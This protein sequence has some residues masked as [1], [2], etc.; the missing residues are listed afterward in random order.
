MRVRI[1]V[2]N[3]SEARFYDSIGRTL[4][5]SGA[6]INPAGRVHERDLVSD[7]PGRVFDRAAVSGHRRGATARHATGPEHT[8]R[9]H[10]IE[11]FARRIGATLEHAWRARRYDTLVLIAGPAF[12]GRLRPALPSA[13]RAV[14]AATVRKD[15]VGRPA[16]ELLDYLP[17]SLFTGV[18]RFERAKRAAPGA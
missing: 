14:V 2:A 5:D 15:V 13:V 16:E 11:V 12:L 7:R 9:R 10:S 17:R 3:Q 18:P 4:I 6:L 8:A 1:V